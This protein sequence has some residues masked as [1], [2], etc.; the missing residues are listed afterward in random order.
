M[1]SVEWTPALFASID[2]KDTQRLLSFLSDD[3]RFRFGN[4]PAAVGR[5]AIREAVNGF[6]ASIA[7]CRHDVANVWAPN[8]HVICQ[9]EVT[10]TRHD[11]GV[12]TLPFVNVFRM[13]G[14]LIREYAI[15]VDASMLFSASLADETTA[16]AGRGPK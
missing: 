5:E 2:A 15:Y 16:A 14:S 12:L 11:G 1:T 13:A 4:L 8:G 6:F 10:Y 7:A 9:G 3:A